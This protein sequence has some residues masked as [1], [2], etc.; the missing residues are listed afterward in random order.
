MSILTGPIL[1]TVTTT[2]PDTGP[3]RRNPMEAQRIRT[4]SDEGVGSFW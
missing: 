3:L 2:E 1:T 4:G